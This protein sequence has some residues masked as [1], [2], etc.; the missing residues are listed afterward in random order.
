MTKYFSDRENKDCSK[1]KTDQISIQVCNGI[2]M[3]VNGLIG[4]NNLAKDFP[5]QCQDG[6]GIIGVD[7]HSFYATAKSVI[8][9]I[10]FLPEY[11]NIDTISPNFLEASPFEEDSEKQDEKIKQFTYNTL[12]F[13]EF[14]FRHIYDVENDHYHNKFGHYELKFHQTTSARE[15]FVSDVNEIFERNHIA[16]KMY[17]NGEIQRIIDAELEKLI[18]AQTEPIENDLRNLLQEAK[19]IGYTETHANEG[20]SIDFY[21]KQGLRPS[22][23]PEKKAG[24]FIAARF[25]KKL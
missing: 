2:A 22:N 17:P 23:A 12:D 10:N 8:P 11:G 20:I 18:D 15:K 24:P 16:F 1:T 9:T 7:K 13:I 14:V 4:N 3:L 19:A 25:E 21:T 5:R 6:N